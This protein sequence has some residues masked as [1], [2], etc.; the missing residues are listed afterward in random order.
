MTITPEFFEMCSEVKEE[1][2]LN[3][4]VYLWELLDENNIHRNRLI[5]QG[6]LSDNSALGAMV[7]KEFQFEYFP[8][9][10]KGKRFIIEGSKGTHLQFIHK[11]DIDEFLAEINNVI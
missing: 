1:Y 4:Y 10:K 5:E 2:E 11:K 9:T 3:G 8:I 7:G 6:Y